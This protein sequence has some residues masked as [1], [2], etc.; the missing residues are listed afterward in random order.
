MTSADMI[1][2]KFTKV[3][4]EL[5]QLDDYKIKNIIDL[6]RMTR[7]LETKEVVDQLTERFNSFS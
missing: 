5:K 1:S 7:E 3:N 4:R 2:M 6:K